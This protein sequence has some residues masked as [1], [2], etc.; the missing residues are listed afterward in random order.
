MRSSEREK[1]I[2]GFVTVNYCVPTWSMSAMASSCW[3]TERR[4]A[5]AGERG[6]DIP[7]LASAN[8]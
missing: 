1:L 4:A 5:A 3:A 7:P 8:N 6:S 2:M